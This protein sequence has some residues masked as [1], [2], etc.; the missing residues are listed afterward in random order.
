MEMKL[1]L[2]ANLIIY[3]DYYTDFLLSSE[4]QSVF[5]YLFIISG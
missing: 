3:P 5:A 1:S 4:F 2:E